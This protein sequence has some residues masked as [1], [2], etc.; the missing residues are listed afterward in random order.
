MG[1]L[2]G[3]VTNGIVSALSREVTIENETMNL[4]QTNASI[5]AG[6]SGGGLFDKNGLLVGV[7]NAKAAGNNVEGIGFAIPIDTAKNVIEQIMD[8]GYVKGRVTSG[9]TLIDILDENT[10]RQYSVNEL[11]V[12]IYSVAEGSNAEKAGLKSGYIVKSV[13][14]TKVESASDFKAVIKK[15]KVGDKIKVTVSN[16]MSEGSVEY[17][18]SEKK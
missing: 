5:N 2:S 4:I 12:Y 15:L 3:T 17:K 7:V 10:A 13:N 8:Y 18:L 16:G 1:E 11:G 6:N 14:G 9:L